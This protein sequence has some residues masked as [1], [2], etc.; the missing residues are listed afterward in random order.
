M[1]L[2][3]LPNAQ[4]INGGKIFKVSSYMLNVLLCILFDGIMADTADIDG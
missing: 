2:S 4:G 1:K 3:K